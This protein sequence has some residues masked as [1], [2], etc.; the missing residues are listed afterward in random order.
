MSTDADDASPL[1]RLVAADLVADGLLPEDAAARAASLVDA[2]LSS[3]RSAGDRPTTSRLA[4]EVAGYLG[5]ILVVAGAAV[6]LASQWSQLSAWGRVLALLVSAVVLGAAAVA[7]RLTV[8]SSPG[9]ADLARQARLLLA[10]TLGVGAAAVAGGAA[11]VWGLQGADLEEPVPQR[12]G[13]AVACALMVLVYAV[14]RTAIAHLG[15]AVTAMLTV[16]ALVLTQDPVDHAGLVVAAAYLALGSLWVVLTERGVLEERRLGQLVGGTIAVIGAQTAI[17]D[18]RPWIA[19]LLLAA[20]GAAA[21]ALY[22]RSLD[23]PYLGVGVLA[24]TLAA[25][26]AAV[27]LS[28][29]A[30]GAAGALLVAGAVLLTASALGLRLRRQGGASSNT[31]SIA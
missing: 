27:D 3:S 15:T 25:T 9:V 24:L 14:T 29:G 22:A 17:V 5:G 4:A 16:L 23:W 11:G 8:P 10:G 7:V 6:F 19:Y 20:V 1:A 21:F 2:R 31:R 30:L 13:F 26:E 18:E 12:I 28:D